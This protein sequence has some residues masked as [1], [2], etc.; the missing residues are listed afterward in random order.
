LIYHF[1]QNAVT[2]DVSAELA[3]PTDYSCFVVTVKL[4]KQLKQSLLFSMFCGL[5]ILGYTLR[6]LGSLAG[7]GS[8]GGKPVQQASGWM[9]TT[10]RVKVRRQLSSVAYLGLV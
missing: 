9:V 1:V 5:E 3:V 4:L 6:F 10:A 8:S 2:A 7:R